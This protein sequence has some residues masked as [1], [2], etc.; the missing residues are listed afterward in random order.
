MLK[1]SMYV[2]LAMLSHWILVGSGHQLPQASARG[3]HDG[4]RA[5]NPCVSVHHEEVSLAN[6]SIDLRGPCGLGRKAYVVNSHRKMAVLATIRVDWEARG[7]RGH[8]FFD[9]RVS[10][11]ADSYL[12]CTKDGP[13]TKRFSV[14]GWRPAP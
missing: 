9:R 6:V 13:K 4:P 2:A 10:P 14:S 3:Q 8:Y 7:K 11:G 12:G 5:E 1:L